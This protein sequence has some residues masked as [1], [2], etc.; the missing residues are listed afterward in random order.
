MHACGHD[1]HMTCL[2]GT[3][4]WLADH[5]DRWSGT[6]VLIGQPAEE[7]IGGAKEMLA[8]GLYTRFPKP[9]FALALHVAHDLETGKVALHQRPGDGRLD[10]GRTSPI[11]G[12]GGHGA[13]PHT[14][15]D[16]IVLAALVVLDLQTIVS[17]EVNPIHPA[18]V[19][20]GS[21]HGGTKHNIIPNE[22]RLQLTLR[23]FRDD[24]RDQLDRGDQA[25]GRR[26]WP[27]PTGP[28]SRS[29]RSA[30]PPRRRSTRPSLV[31]RVVPALRQ[32]LG[33]ANV[34]R[35]RA[36]DG[37]R[38]LRPV[39]PGRRPDLHVPARDD[40]ARA[41]RRGQGE[42]RD[43]ALAPLGA[44]PPRPR[45]PASGPASA[46]MTAAVVEPAPARAR[47]SPTRTTERPTCDA[48]LRSDRPIPTSCSA[49][50]S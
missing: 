14:T 6:V 1:V 2:V 4:R 50:R 31:A 30:R 12:K 40:P 46:A 10:V 16:P 49:R 28:P 25:A 41:G 38:G 45:R 15:V 18:V 11:R 39:R 23:A 5:K 43:A 7:K 27:R 32:A 17:R 36:G 44:L 33:A 42:G 26:A 35:G 34:E 29:S 22:V 48:A 24:V 47:R 21:I 37:G 19:T 20:V 8:D 3:A 13:V 9:D